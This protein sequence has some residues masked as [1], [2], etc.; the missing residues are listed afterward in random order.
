MGYRNW[1]QSGVKWKGTRFWGKENEIKILYLARVNVTEPKEVLNIGFCLIF[2]FPKPCSLPF[3]NTLPPI[4]TNFLVR[5]C[6]SLLVSS[7]F[8][9]HFFYRLS[10]LA[11]APPPSASIYRHEQT[12]AFVWDHCKE[13]G[14]NSNS[15][16]RSSFV[17]TIL[18][19]RKCRH[20]NA[21]I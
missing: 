14:K 1:R 13:R 2:L 16:F 18:N 19:I 10:R 4:H 8:Y 7:I 5:E 17:C 12:P 3:Y 20:G 9:Y 15:S 11:R 6:F 21:S